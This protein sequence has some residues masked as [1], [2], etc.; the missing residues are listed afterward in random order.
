L[1]AANLDVEGAIVAPGGQI[2]LTT[3]DFSPFSLL[4]FSQ[5]FSTPA[6]DPSRGN[7]TLGPSAVLNAAGLIVDNRAS[8]PTA[9]TVPLVTSGGAVAIQSIN[10][11]LDAGSVIDVAGGAVISAAGKAG[12]G[13]GGSIS[14]SAGQ[15][16]SNP[17]LAGLIG[18]Q[19]T[20]GAEL[21]GFSGAKG[22]SLSILA[23]SIQVGG[24]TTNPTTLLLSPDFFN[25]GGFT[26]YSL[27][28]LGV[29]GSQPGQ[30]LPGVLIV[31]GTVIAPTALNL[32][33]NLTADEVT[34]GTTLAPVGV[35]TPV[36][37]TFNAAGVTDPGRPGIARRLGAG[38]RR[39][40][41]YRSKRI[42][43]VE[44]SNRHGPW[45]GYRLGWHDQCER[46]QQHPNRFS[47]QC[48]GCSSHG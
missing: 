41:R 32:I 26:S 12:Y 40:H 18:G 16:K 8:S 31:P 20:L 19:L 1:F 42:R 24:T 10:T 4:L 47:R 23:P 6:F 9:N 34:L 5:S 25:Q 29:V 13:G 22:A 15:E 46:W 43:F 37:L 30:F 48:R 28:G 14:I 39:Q 38:C 7:F 36:R 3:F 33:A 45:L 27:T 11:T 2:G 35:R 17:L 44:W 21:E